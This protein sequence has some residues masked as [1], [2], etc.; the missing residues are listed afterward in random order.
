[1]KKVLMVIILLIAV[2]LNAQQKENFFV[3]TKGDSVGIFLL[4]PPK[5]QEGFL[6]YRSGPLPSESEFK[7]ISKEP[8]KA[9]IDP[10]EARMIVG[11]DW[12]VLEKATKTSDAFEILRKLRSS[13]LYGGLLSF[14]NLSVAKVTGRWFLDTTAQ[15]G[16]EY[17]YKI[18]V[19]D[20]RGK[21]KQ[22][23][24]KKIL[25]KEV[26]P[27]AP[28]KIKVEVGDE[29]IKLN[30]EY[31]KWSG[32]YDDIAVQFSVYRK[33]GDGRFE[34]VNK[35]LILRDDYNPPVFE[36][37]FIENGLAY[38][39]FITAVDPMGRESKH[40]EIVK[41]IPKDNVPPSIPQS[42][43]TETGD[44]KIN[45]N[46]AMSQEL[47]GAG[48]NIY[49]SFGLDKPLLKLNKKIIPLEYPFY[50][51]STVKNGIQY[52]YSV[53][54]LDKNGNESERCNSVAVIATDITKPDPPSNV[55][56]KLEKRNLV[57]KWKPSK[58]NDLA[59]YYIYRGE[60]MEIQPRITH[61]PIKTFSYDDKGYKGK[62]LLPGKK[63]YFSISAVDSMNNE[64]EKVSI[65]I[66]VPDDEPPLPPSSITA[67]N[68]EGKYVLVSCGK[69]ISMDATSYCI[70]RNQVGQKPIKIKVLDSAPFQYVDTAVVKG[71]SYIYFATALDTVKNESEFTRGDTV[72]VRDNNPPPPISY[73]KASVNSKGVKIEWEKAFD[74]DLAGYNIYRSSVP[75]G[76][77]EKLNSKLITE[78]YFEDIS[79]TTTYY[80]KVVTVDTSGNESITDLYAQA[81]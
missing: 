74:F 49:R 32:N 38:Q 73:I 9:V 25:L 68:A 21:E 79:G 78:F 50:T 2:V 17:D 72:I 3:M 28:L 42:L 16:K 69:S 60:S 81:E 7:L 37:L 41:A 54:S 56:Y 11:D 29:K 53:S 22:S 66:T 44:K 19:V 15:K 40:S 18:T 36:D 1:M 6:V 4:E 45:L 47:D 35:K 67:E 26:F 64:S 48:Y 80:Y 24:N 75:T 8:V 52:F 34:K 76:I 20:S 62:G 61:E 39:Y 5:T 58:A 23:Y 70:Y 12:D 77:Y 55:T 59:G 13:D 65:I 33:S 57:L 71:K 27:A 31:P 30:W 14:L 10:S 51:D 63:F 43:V 46:W